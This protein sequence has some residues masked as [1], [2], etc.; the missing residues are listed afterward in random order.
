MPEIRVHSEV[1][2]LRCV[3]MH[4]PGREHQLVPPNRREEF[5]VEDI[6]YLPA[7]RENTKVIQ[8]VIRRCGATVLQFRDLLRDILDQEDSRRGCLRRLNLLNHGSGYP[9]IDVET[10]LLVRYLVE[11]DGIDGVPVLDPIPNV[12]FQRDI[13]MVISN[14]AVTAS[15]KEQVRSRE[16][17]IFRAI[18]DHHPIFAN[19]MKD[20]AVHHCIEGG[21]VCVA[22]SKVAIIGHGHRTETIA[23]EILAS[24]LLNRGFETVIAVQQPNG[25]EHMHLDTVFTLVSDEECLIY[26]PFVFGSKRRGLGLPALS[27]FRH[28]ANGATEFKIDEECNLLDCL[29]DL[30]L[31]YK[32]II[33]GGGD[34]D[35]ISADQEQW[36]DGVNAFAVAPGR[37]LL[38]DRNEATLAEFEKSGYTIRVIQ[39]LEDARSILEEEERVVYAVPSYEL[40]RARGGPH[41]LSMPLLRD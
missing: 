41:C 33:C 28:S 4:T 34:G 27:F 5:L 36:W 19:A 11:G 31:H 23:A 13:G 16:S 25:R 24:E 37:V 20:L 26:I 30:G 39:S 29:A 1:G 14:I 15:M 35:H 9:L 10:D 22:S 17:A 40:C 38:Y 12:A 32:P 3:L 7:A 8:E 21:D 18:V 2:R 6:L